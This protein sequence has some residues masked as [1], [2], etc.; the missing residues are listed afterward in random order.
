MKKYK[1]NGQNIIAIA[2]KVAHDHLFDVK[3]G[4]SFDPT[5]M[6]YNKYME[7]E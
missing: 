1:G 7:A 6:D 3:N 4:S 5:Q 2:K